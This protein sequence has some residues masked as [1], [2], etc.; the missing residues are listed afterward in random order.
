MRFKLTSVL[1]VLVL[2]GC[3]PQPPRVAQAP[4]DDHPAADVVRKYH[5]VR[6]TADLRTLTDN[7][8][9][10]LPLLIRAAQQMDSIFWRQSWGTPDSLLAAHAHHEAISLALRIN[11]GPYDRL[12]GNRS[13]L[14]E[15]AP[16]PAGAAFYPT[17]LTVAEFEAAD[18]PDKR[19]PYTRLIRDAKGQ[20]QTQPYREA[21]A[22]YP[23]T[24]ARL[25]RMAANL[26]ETHDL[27][28]YL[29]A[30]A[31]ALETDQYQGSDRAWLGM[32]QNRL[33]IVIGPIET[34]E[35]QFL[36]LKAAHEA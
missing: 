17:D 8:R 6:L 22:P 20:L 4:A 12:D 11:Y 18:L 2:A 35:D 26:A 29:L 34:Y 23:Q 28:A 32:K 25:L 14:Q 24:A 19:S 27:K 13:F 1:L 36:G 15:A 33:D 31:Q 30:R 5:P 9:A 21:Y 3:G 7:E 10:M 16:K